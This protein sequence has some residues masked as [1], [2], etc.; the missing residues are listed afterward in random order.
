[1]L[2]NRPRVIFPWLARLTPALKGLAP[3]GVF[4]RIA[5][6]LRVNTSM[7]GWRGRSSR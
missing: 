5:G 2:A 6:W 3:F 1:V 7:L 4:Y